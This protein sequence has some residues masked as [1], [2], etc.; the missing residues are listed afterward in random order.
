V[1]THAPA[2][3]KDL[4]ARPTTD[5]PAS[6]NITTWPTGSAL[7]T[8]IGE[9]TPDNPPD[10][11]L[12]KTT[13]GSG[14]GFFSVGLGLTAGYDLG[15]IAVTVQHS[16]ANGA[17]AGNVRVS[18][19]YAGSEVGAKSVTSTTTWTTDVVTFARADWSGDI[20]DASKLQLR[21]DLNNTTSGG[22]GNV[23]VAFA[24][25]DV[26]KLKPVI[27]GT[28]TTGGNM[29][30]S[31]VPASL[32][33]AALNVDWKDLEP[34]SA[35]NQ[36]FTG[37][38]WTG[39]GWATITKAIQ[40]VQAN[41]NLKGIR[42]RI[43]AGQAAPNFVLGMCTRQVGCSAGVSVLDPQHG[44]PYCVPCFWQGNY[45]KEYEELMR[46]VARRF[47]G[48]DEIREV[49]DSGCMTTFAEPFVRAHGD[50]Q[51]NDNLLAAGYTFAGD[52]GC[53]EAA[54][55]VAQNDFIRTRTSIAL[56]PWDEPCAGCNSNDVTHS[57]PD[58]AAFVL[59][60]AHARPSLGRKL[61]VQANHLNYAYGCSG[62]DSYSS[63]ACLIKNEAGPKGFQTTMNEL[64]CDHKDATCNTYAISL[65]GHVEGL[66]GALR[67]GDADNGWFVEIST[68]FAWSTINASDF[69]TRD[70]ALEANAN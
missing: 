40:T 32:G 25:A 4:V 18:L 20:A 48:A 19:V 61:V 64:L 10:Q 63:D 49:V 33:Y 69:V 56:N 15:Q 5:G 42:L 45:Q 22:T 1:T 30:P 14:N 57:F 28:M 44:T 55:D 6:S 17:T 16:I 26:W 66:E 29:P 27:V 31:G 36:H 59:D 7:H 53:H 51:S 3:P 62:G 34:D 21:F 46:E 41:P 24:S 70:A 37:N 38:D 58:T 35:G 68:G 54:L 47:D 23:R 12:V 8:V 2:T 9:T 13:P 50:K 11:S 67:A 65:N 52:Q 60:D 43:M 39:P